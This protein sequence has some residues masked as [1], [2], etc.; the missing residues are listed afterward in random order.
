ML[1]GT[2]DQIKHNPKMY[3]AWLKGMIYVD[4]NEEKSRKESL[5]KMERILNSGTSVIVF[6]EGGL[7]NSENKLVNDLFASPYTLAQRT[8]CDVVPLVMFNEYGTDDIHVHVG[9]P[10][11]LI[12]IGEEA[13]KKVLDEVNKS[14]L[15]PLRKKYN[16]LNNTLNMPYQDKI[17]NELNKKLDLLIDNYLETIAKK[18]ALRELR[19]YLGLTMFEFMQKYATHLSRSPLG[20]DCRLDYLEERRKTYLTTKWSNKDVWK[21]ELTV[22][23]D[24][25]NPTP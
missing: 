21:E 1:I 17:F 15:V 2:T 19:D 24:K 18:E 12:K 11:D 3:M 16:N 8:G 5:D 20:Q 25:Y 10:M 22:Y 4:R 9:E 14:I 7:N 13:K 23:Q 6:A